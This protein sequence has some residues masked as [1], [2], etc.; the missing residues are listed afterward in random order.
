MEAREIIASIAISLLITA[1]I[2]FVID[3]KKMAFRSGD[4]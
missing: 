4:I 3:T 2:I 1:I